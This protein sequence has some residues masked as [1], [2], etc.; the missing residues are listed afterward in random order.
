MEFNKLV[1]E[2]FGPYRERNEFNLKTSSESPIIL[3]G[4]KN[5]AGK[6]TLFNSIQV[7]LHGK[8]AL[9]SKTSNRKYE[10]YIESKLHEYP[11]GKAETASIRLEFEYANMGEVDHYSVERSWRDRGESIVEDLEVR[12]NGTI[13]SELDEDQWQDFLK[14][15]IPPGISQLFFF[16]GEKVKQL[17][18]AVE[19]EDEFEESLFSLLGLNLIDRLDADLSIYI[20]K[21]LDES[22]VES[23]TNEID[24]LEETIEELQQEKEGYEKERDEKASELE[25]V[26]ERI[27]KLEDKIAQEGGSYADKREDL[28]ERRAKLEAEIDNHEDQIRE[29]VTGAYPFSLAPELCKDAVERLKEEEEKQSKMAA[30]SQ[31]ADELDETLEDGVLQDAGIPEEKSDEVS[32]KLQSVIKDRLSE[33]EDET[34][35]VHYFSEAQRNEMYSLVDEALSDVPK[36]LDEVSTELEGEIRELQQIESKLSRAPDEEVIS[37]YIEEL[38]NLTERKGTLKSEIESLEE[39]ISRV[40]NKI[41]TLESKVEKKIEKKTSSEEVSERAELA[42]DAQSAL[43]DYRSRLVER[44][45]E[46]LESALSKRYLSLSNKQGFYQDIKIESDSLEVMIE[47]AHGGYKKQ[48]ELSA[49]ERQIFATSLLWAL[50]DISDRP[51]PFIIDTPMGRLDSDHR[52]NLV[53]DFFPEVA[54]QVLLFSTDTEISD[55]YYDSLSESVSQSYRLNHQEGEGYTELEKGYFWS[56]D[57]SDTETQEAVQ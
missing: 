37:P 10:E 54:H 11:G 9:G 18:S 31:I 14:E 25:G 45:L 12:R 3:F 16:D 57:E 56:K 27:S 20:S 51:L 4:G 21:K 35:L 13:P 55:E 39:E 43:E 34:N 42:S 23:I 24:E 48:S 38:N 28:K 7:C 49:G 47:T 50:A 5:G 22:D 30:R 52:G 15:L 36:E 8:S 26:E 19:K 53:E 6:T 33:A 2:D 41:G 29:L 46:R 17:A 32:E 40:E 1:I 44:K